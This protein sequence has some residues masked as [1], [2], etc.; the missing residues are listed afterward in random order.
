MN[1]TD[2]LRDELERVRAERDELRQ[3]ITDQG[4]Q[5]PSRHVVRRVTA[6][7]LVMLSCMSFLTGGVGI[8]A[9]RNFLDTDIWVER[10]GPLIHDPAVQAAVSTKLTDSVMQLVDPEALFNEVLPKRGKVLAGPLSGAVRGFV[11]DQV[12]KVVASDRFAQLWQE[13][14]R[15]AHTA[16]VR[17][18]KGDSDVVTAGSDSVTIDL[19]PVINRVLAR[20]TSISPELLGRTVN[21]PDVQIDEVPA[22]VIN[23][24]NERFDANLPEDFGQITVYDQGKLKELQ[25][26][27]RLFDQIVWLSVAVFVIST[28]GALA[29]SVD[30]R[31]TLLQLSIADAVLLVLLRRG[32][33]RAQEQVLDLVRVEENRPAV[34]AVTDAMFQGL[35]DGT[36]LLLW[37]MAV[38]IVVALVTG[39][40]P[41][42]HALRARVGSA[43]LSVASAARE[44]GSDPATAAWVVAHRGPLQFA[45]AAV[46][47]VLLWWLELSWFAMLVVIALAGVGIWL[48]SRLPDQP[49]DD[50]DRTQGPPVPGAAPSATV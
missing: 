34:K 13:V 44:R 32:A 42:A 15:R 46:A 11:D 29:V 1:E 18:L 26:A 9:S 36:R 24:F 31:R 33:M 40:W 45:V 39:P 10:T 37:L 5:R 30:R 48:L 3:T 20:I 47:L 16:A 43:V 49:S 28:V 2:A 6:I 7:T 23:R 14:N 21:I 25:D 35:F 12:A 38:I 19:I 22:T 27:V 41:R 50:G 4:A 8:W 17:V